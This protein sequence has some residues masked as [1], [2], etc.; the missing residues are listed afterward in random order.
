MVLNQRQ[1]SNFRLGRPGKLLV[2]GI[3]QIWA[4]EPGAITGRWVSAEHYAV[5]GWFRVL[6]R[7][8]G[9]SPY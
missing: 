8:G 1:F 4:R 3:A 6:L 9:A 7:Q 2:Q 5:V